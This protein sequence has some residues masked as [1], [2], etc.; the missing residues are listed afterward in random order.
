M[1][2]LRSTPDERSTTS[3]ERRI[4]RRVHRLIERAPQSRIWNGLVEFLVFGAKQAWA[5]VFGAAMLAVLFATRLWYPD[6]ALLARN[7]AVTIAAVVIQILM[8]VCRLET[9]RELRVVVLFHVVGTGMELFKTSV[10]S[11][12]Y[13]PAGVLHLAAS[14]CSADS[15][16]PRSA[17]TW[18]G[19]SA[20]ST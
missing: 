19:C 2:S 5:C 13:E 18:C 4:N 20:S 17:P 11:W 9:L 10:G 15:C 6:D 1:T 7:D 12:S 3:L 8:V 14:R 16:T